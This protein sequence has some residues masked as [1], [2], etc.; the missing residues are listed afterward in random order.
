MEKILTNTAAI[1]HS[2]CPYSTSQQ[3]FLSDFFGWLCVFLKKAVSFQVKL[4]LNFSIQILL[5]SVSVAR[6]FPQG[7][8]PTL[9]G[10][11]RAGWGFPMHQLLPKLTLC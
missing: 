9:W 7:P 2:S 5:S 10:E 8:S 11:E 3:A 1:Q 4:E 6:L